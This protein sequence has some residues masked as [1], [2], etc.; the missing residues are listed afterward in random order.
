MS[1]K[2]LIEYIQ[3][4]LE[5]SPMI[6]TE[7]GIK[8]L[9]KL[10]EIA[11]KENIDWALAGGIA[12]HLYGSPR[13]TKD[14]DT[15]SAGFLSLEG[16][17]RL[18]FGGI[19]YEVKVG[20]KLVTV[21]WIVRSDDYAEYYRQALKDAVILPNGLKV[22]TPEWLVILKS[23]AGRAKDRDDA[24]YL[25]QRKKTVKR[26]KIREHVLKVGGE[27]AWRFAKLRFQEFYEVADGKTST[28]EKYYIEEVK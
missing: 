3:Q 28:Q 20:K 5:H 16:K 2:E 22:L 11:Q 12:M 18:S 13:M 10:A 27:E 9:K 4:N 14:V 26:E 19:S 24:V 15:I 6:D 21:D 8:A 7:T 25:L 17:H 23:I 1:E